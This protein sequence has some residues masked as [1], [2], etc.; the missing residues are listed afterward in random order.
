MMTANRSIAALLDTLYHPG[1]ARIDLSLARVERF[2]AQ[3]GDPHKKLPPVIHVAGTNGKGSLVANLHSIF[4]AAGYTPHR[5]ISP[6]LIRFNERIVIAG[7][8]IEDDYLESLLKRVAAEMEKQPVTFFEATTAAAFLAFSENPA[9][10]VLLETG[11]GGLLDA[12]NI[13][14]QPALTAI[15]PVALDHCAYLGDNIAAIAR[16][17]AGIIKRG[18]PCVVG[19]QTEEAAQVIAAHT[20][21]LHA[22]LYPM[23]V[24]WNWQ[25]K[26]RKAVYFSPKRR[27][28]AFIPGLAGEHQYDNAA[29]AIACFDQLPQFRITDTHIAEGLAN[30]SWPGRL[31]I[32]SDHPYQKLL[33]PHAELWLDGGHNPQ[34]GEVLAAWLKEQHKEVHLICGMVKGKDSIG[35]LKA[36]SPYVTSLVAIAI[37]GESDSQLAGDILATAKEAGISAVQA[38]SIEKALQTIAARAKNPCIVC[39]CGS[40]Y[41]AGRVLAEK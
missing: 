5:Y 4:T 29:T 17:K 40:L 28:L 13:I 15:T 33:P 10:V 19:K 16:E 6:H 36:L 20:K 32:L 2:L 3:L 26:N 31:Q 35:Y 7:R 38:A 23:G 22:P 39:I 8:E 1:L 27:E 41:L 37:P 11:M 9:D 21:T 25:M 24:E 18:V 30:V 14:E 12:T 34:G